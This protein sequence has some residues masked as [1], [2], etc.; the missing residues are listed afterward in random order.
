MSKDLVTSIVKSTGISTANDVALISS[1]KKLLE[2][3]VVKSEVCY[4]F[5]FTTI[6]F[7]YCI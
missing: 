1:N 2:L 7:I 6:V 3:D 5:I 4:C